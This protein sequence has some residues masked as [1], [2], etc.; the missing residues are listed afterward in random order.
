[1]SEAPLTEREEILYKKYKQNSKV[2]NEFKRL[3]GCDYESCNT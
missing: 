2:S 3:V 1:M